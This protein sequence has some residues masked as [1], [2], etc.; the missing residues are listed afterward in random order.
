MTNQE[1][2]PYCSYEKHLSTDIQCPVVGVGEPLDNEGLLKRFGTLEAALT[3]Y[4]LG[5]EPAACDVMASG[6]HINA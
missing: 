3:F 4:G 2:C 5:D 6:A 1:Q